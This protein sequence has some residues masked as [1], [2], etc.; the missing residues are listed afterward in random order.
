MNIDSRGSV[1]HD[2]EFG[3]RCE[4]KKDARDH[5]LLIDVHVCVLFFRAGFEF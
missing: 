5:H 4:H 3:I 1:A 2:D